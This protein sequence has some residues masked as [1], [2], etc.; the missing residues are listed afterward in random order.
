MTLLGMWE[1]LWLLSRTVL[2]LFFNFWTL[3]TGIVYV[4]LRTWVFWCP[5][6]EVKVT[7]QESTVNFVSSVNLSGHPCPTSGLMFVSMCTCTLRHAPNFEVKVTLG[8][9]KS[10]MCPACGIY[11]WLTHF[12]LIVTAC[13][14]YKLTFYNKLWH[15][16]DFCSKDLK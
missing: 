11:V 3:F 2:K 16:S 12:R 7:H 14:H 1:N 15:L 8:D 5:N 13:Q 4:Y 10:I 9:Q 6:F